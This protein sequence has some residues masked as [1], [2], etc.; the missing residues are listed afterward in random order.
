M[1]HHSIC[2]GVLTSPRGRTDLHYARRRT[3]ALLLDL[4]GLVNASRRLSLFGFNR[5]AAIS[6]DSR[7]FGATDALA[8]RRRIDACVASAGLSSCVG[9]RVELLAFPRLWGQPLGA[10]GLFLCYSRDGRLDAIVHDAA[11]SSVPSGA[12]A[13][14]PALPP[15][16]PAPGVMSAGAPPFQLRLQV[17]EDRLQ[18][19]VHRRC[20]LGYRLECSFAATRLPW[21][22]RQLL[23]ILLGHPLL[24]LRALRRGVLAAWRLAGTRLHALFGGDQHRLNQ[25]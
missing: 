14:T 24:G 18:V 12:V 19:S 11:L 4:D 10:L 8:L 21:H 3:F 6:L 5:R 22:E 25:E 2:S 7:D 20:T 15:G 1:F 23:G 17:H 13:A 16:E 9:G